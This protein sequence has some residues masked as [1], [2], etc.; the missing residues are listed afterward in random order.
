MD[1]ILSGYKVAMLAAN[2]FSEQDVTQTQRVLRQAGA[3]VHIV[4]SDQGLISG[5]NGNNWGL[6][7]AIDVSLSTALGTDYSALIIPGGAR[8]LEK[9]QLTAHTKRFVRS[10]L[11]AGKPAVVMNDALNL[12]VLN[13]L[14]KGHVVTGPDE[15]QSAVLKAAGV[16]EED[17]SCYTDGHLMTGTY[18]EDTPDMVEQVVDFLASYMDMDQ[19]A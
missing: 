2:G 11:E 4:S 13:D 8:S 7:F 14:M 9:L 19:A 16:W 5:W 6:N 1:K 3:L 12:L 17:V 15:L 10:F 18:N